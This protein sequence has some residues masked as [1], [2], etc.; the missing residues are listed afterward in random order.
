[1]ILISIVLSAVVAIPV[2][3]MFFDKLGETGS[4]FEAFNLKLYDIGIW[5]AIINSFVSALIYPLYAIF[6]LV[7]YLK[8]PPLMAALYENLLWY[9]LTN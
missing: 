6:S 7:L 9:L 5:S 4:I 8:E 3:I 2:V 1:M